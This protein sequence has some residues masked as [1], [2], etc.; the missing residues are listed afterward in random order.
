M[1]AAANYGIVTDSSSQITEGLV[2][3]FGVRTVPMTITIDGVDHL[4]GVD[5][6]AD[7]FYEHF[8][9]GARPDVST[10]QPSPGMFVD[11]YL[12]LVAQGRSEIWSI[13]I[14]EQMSGTVGAAR[15]A[16]REVDVPVHVV[17]SG[18]ASFG[19]SVCVWA[20]A[21]ALARGGN[22]E[23]VRRRI[24]GLVA[25]LGTAFMAG[26]PLLTERGGRAP[27]IELDGDGIQVL[28][29]HG[30]D[31]QVLQ[32]VST[33]EDTIDVMSTYAASWI[34]REPN[35]ITVA[36]GTADAP[37]RPLSDRLERALD[38]VPGVDDVVHYRVGPSVGAHT[39]PGT[40]GLFVF[41]TIR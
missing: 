26:V 15:I 5:I 17:D 6:D 7:A 25:R 20:A 8:D 36:I 32:R 2:R 31:L 19:V 4:E 18:S 16:A 14:A 34:E 27:G 13:H 28:V 24:D 30:G 40:F 23:D 22:V 33:V 10:S 12:D 21:V 9:D 39:G 35:G 38:G 37:S 11:A 1:P 41:P 3:R 29:M